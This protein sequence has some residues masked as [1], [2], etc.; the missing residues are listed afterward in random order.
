ML[1]MLNIN[2][3][4]T[5]LFSANKNNTL[6]EYCNPQTEIIKGPPTGTKKK[7]EKKKLPNP[8]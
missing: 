7:I 2:Q 5:N 1:V 3:N 4:F 6:C 8:S